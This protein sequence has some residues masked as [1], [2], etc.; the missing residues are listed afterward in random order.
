MR[1]KCETLHCLELKV[2]CWVIS[3]WVVHCDEYYALH[4]EFTHLT[5]SVHLAVNLL[6]NLNHHVFK[7]WVHD[8]FNFGFLLKDLLWLCSKYLLLL[9]VLHKFV[10]LLWFA[11][12]HAFARCCFSRGYRLFHPTRS[13]CLYCDLRTCLFNATRVQSSSTCVL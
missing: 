13:C 2:G 12:L 6:F 7:K 9:Q 1:L 5:V 4:L 10:L 8:F 11:Q 3:L